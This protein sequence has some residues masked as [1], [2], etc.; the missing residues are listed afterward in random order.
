M[1][2]KNNKRK[3]ESVKRIREAFFLLHQKYDLSDIKVT[4]ICR[5]AKINRSTFYT[6]YTDIYDLAD[7]I[8]AELYNEIDNVFHI[9]PDLNI[10]KEDFLNLFVH[11]KSKRE[12]YS[13]YFKLGY[14]KKLEKKLNK[15]NP[16]ALVRERNIDYRVEFFRNGLNAIIKI[17]LENG[18]KESPEMMLDILI[19]EYRGRI[20]DK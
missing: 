12:L 20:F 11:I 14:D 8:L 19:L 18:C 15:A 7:Q 4:D 9:D 5:H 1:N 17:W 16:E 10:S 3:Q 2:T 6:N 13:L